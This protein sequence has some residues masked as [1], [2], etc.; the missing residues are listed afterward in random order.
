MIERL[1][2][3]GSVCDVLV[4]VVA[5]LVT[6]LL[7]DSDRTRRRLQGVKAVRNWPLVHLESPN[8]VQPAFAITNADPNL[9]KTPIDL[10]T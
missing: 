9:S 6:C 4:G 2:L 8:N 7:F 5:L 1:Y 3:W 10:N